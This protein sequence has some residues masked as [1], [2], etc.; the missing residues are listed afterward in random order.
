VGSSI[1]VADRPLTSVIPVG[2][3]A[4]VPVRTSALES[5]GNAS[6][7]VVVPVIDGTYTAS[8]GEVNLG[9]SLSTPLSNYVLRLNDVLLIHSPSSLQGV[10][11]VRTRVDGD[12]ITIDAGLAPDASSVECALI[13]G[14]QLF[15]DQITDPVTS[16]VET[17][18]V[19]SGELYDLQGPWL[20][21]CEN[22]V[23]S[24]NAS[25]RQEETITEVVRRVEAYAQE[26]DALVLKSVSLGSGEETA[27]IVCTQTVDRRGFIASNGR[28]FWLQQGGIYTLLL[29]L[30]SDD[31]LGEV[32]KGALIASNRLMLV[33][34]KFA[35]RILHL[36]RDG[37]TPLSEL[38]DEILAGCVSPQKPFGV[39]VFDET[40]SRFDNPSWLGAI[41]AG[42]IDG[43]LTVG[44]SLRVLVRCVNLDDNLVSK[45]VPVLTAEN[46]T[47]PTTV[48]TSSPGL[49]FTISQAGQALTVFTSV[50]QDDIT[51]G[52]PPI[53]HGRTTHI[54]VW[55]TQSSQSSAFYLES[56]IEIGDLERGEDVAPRVL[57]ADRALLNSLTH[58]SGGEAKGLPIRLSDTDVQSL[59][60]AT[61]TVLNSGGLPPVC[62]DVVSLNGVTFCFGQASADRV[63]PVLYAK[64]F[65]G[66]NGKYTSATGLFEGTDEAVNYFDTY[67]FQVGDQLVVI[68]PGSDPDTGIGIPRGVYDIEERSTINAVLIDDLLVPSGEVPERVGY[69]I[70]RPHVIEWPHIQSDEDVWYSRTDAFEPENFLSRILRLSE[71]GDIF[72]RVIPI[73]NYLA[74]LMDQ[75]VHLI[76]MDG[77]TPLVDTIALAGAGTP[78]PDSAFV[79]E[80][81]LYWASSQGARRMTVSNQPDEQGHRA[82]LFL[83]GR[84]EF[85]NFFREAELNGDTVDAGIDTKNGTMRFRRR[86]PD[87][88]TAGS[89]SGFLNSV[90]RNAASSRNTVRDL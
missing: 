59:P 22:S 30:G 90:K 4:S 39:E 47:F 89:L 56:R 3:V 38:G 5:I 55:R 86:S 53:I 78:W 61:E 68:E 14:E 83:D 28:K 35:P 19:K 23:F 45:F 27:S 1:P 76:Y 52:W 49:T 85:L 82:R 66:E 79:F 50:N 24:V 16:E 63:N 10:Y 60:I 17:W 71:T 75:G 31:F 69:Y 26:R 88:V 6:E 32:W 11:P 57:L 74:V 43:D 51:E 20:A 2:V 40:Q 15:V 18:V 21:E 36:R 37:S 81:V 13:Q 12:K 65:F 54:E 77:I 70:R 64:N 9:V 58:T 48:E 7:L 41:R 8:T 73:G 67:D 42:S 87:S 29:D 44:S 62:R 72:R 33:S 34:P 46:S 80:N 84:L 25:R